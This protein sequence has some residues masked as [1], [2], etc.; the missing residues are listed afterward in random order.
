MADGDVGR[1]DPCLCGSGR[2]YKRCCLKQDEAE[3]RSKRQNALVAASNDPN[4]VGGRSA[5][6]NRTLERANRY[7]RRRKV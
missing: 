7:R 1:N 2:K 4:F 3:S 5:V 6:A